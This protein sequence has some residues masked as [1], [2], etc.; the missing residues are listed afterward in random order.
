MGP[1]RSRG[2]THFAVDKCSA[3]RGREVDL[4]LAGCLAGGTRSACAAAR[5]ASRLDRVNRY[6]IDI[7]A[8]DPAMM[9]RQGGFRRIA[10]KR[11]SVWGMVTLKLNL[12]V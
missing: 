10:A 8:I 3:Q 4:P 5:G 2:N 7:D 1:S 6:E 11:Y 12:G 9:S